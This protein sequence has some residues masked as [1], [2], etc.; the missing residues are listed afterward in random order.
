MAMQ[1]WISRLNVATVVAASVIVLSSTGCKSS[2]SWARVPGMSWLS[3]HREE[4]PPTMLADG[5]EKA[6][7]GITSIEEV[8]RVVPVGVGA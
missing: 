4:A 6:A 3:R 8:L 5:L 2:G 1:A 7:Q